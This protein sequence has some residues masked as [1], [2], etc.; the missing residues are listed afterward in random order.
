MRMCMVIHTHIYVF[1]DQYKL[2]YSC[3]FIESNLFILY[4]V[5]SCQNMW[6]EKQLSFTEGSFPKYGTQAGITLTEPYK[7]LE[8]LF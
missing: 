5:R 8:S 1:K 4:R 6:E 7:I 2:V 3:Y